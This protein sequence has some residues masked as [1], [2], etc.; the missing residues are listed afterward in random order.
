VPDEA[1][2]LPGPAGL[3][4]SDDDHPAGRACARASGTTPAAART[5][6]NAANGAARRGRRAAEIGTAMRQLL[7]T[8]PLAG[9]SAHKG[10]GNRYAACTESAAPCRPASKRGLL[11]D[12][13]LSLAKR[14]MPNLVEGL[15]S[16]Q[17][18]HLAG[19]SWSTSEVFTDLKTHAIERDR[20]VTHQPS[21]RRDLSDSYER[22]SVLDTA[23]HRSAR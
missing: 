3:P 10:W 21:L 17:A 9:Q 4:T 16:R 8:R 11:A 2:A 12:S 19:E 5:A 14:R 15:R 20:E 7:R 1:L 13:A 22:S 23:S 18:L 6:N